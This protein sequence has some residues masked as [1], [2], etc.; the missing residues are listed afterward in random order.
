MRYLYTLLSLYYYY[1]IL[2]NILKNKNRIFKTV[3][4]ITQRELNTFEIKVLV[5]DFDGVLNAHGESALHP[6]VIPWLEHMQAIL[7]SDSIFILSNKPFSERIAFFKEHFP[8]IGF[9]QGVRKKPYPDGLEMIFKIKK[10]SQAQKQ[11]VVLVD[12]RILTGMLATCTAGCQG[13]YISRPY[14]SLYKRPVIESFFQVIRYA[15]R[16]C[17]LV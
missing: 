17:F 16:F 6:Q 8:N 9:I 10:L 15:E 3:T 5:L 14:V 13:F 7:G 12:D 4:D 11:H 2:K 1:G